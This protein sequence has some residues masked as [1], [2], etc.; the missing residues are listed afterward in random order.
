MRH[1]HMCRKVS[2][3][4][5]FDKKHPPICQVLFEDQ[6]LDS[7]W[8]RSLNI[9]DKPQNNLTQNANILVVHVAPV[10]KV[11]QTY[12]QAGYPPVILYI[13]YNRT[14]GGYAGDNGYTTRCAPS[15]TERTRF[16]KWIEPSGD[17]Y[18]ACATR[19]EETTTK[20]KVVSGDRTPPAHHHWHCVVASENKDRQPIHLR[21]HRPFLKAN[22]DETDK[23][24]YC[25][26]S[27][28]SVFGRLG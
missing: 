21:D 13:C 2:A 10:H 1:F 12:I 6:H 27:I 5:E 4:T 22:Q 9:V 14:L 15:T 11:V 16:M 7:E 25:N 8:Q 19:N 28:H 20:T 24:A 3:L 17:S 18:H 23:K 26:N